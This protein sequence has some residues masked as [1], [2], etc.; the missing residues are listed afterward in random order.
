MQTLSL[1]SHKDDVIEAAHWRLVVFALVY[2]VPLSLKCKM[3]KEIDMIKFSWWV[4]H[5]EQL[6]N[7]LGCQNCRKKKNC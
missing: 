4:T 5:D 1:L 7:S 2:C 3:Q 6:N